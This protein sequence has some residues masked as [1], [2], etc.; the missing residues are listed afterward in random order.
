MRNDLTC[1][2]AHSLESTEFS[3]IWLRFKSHSLTKFICA[4]GHNIKKKKKNSLT[5]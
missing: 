5:I 4:I 2:H 1:S 3:T